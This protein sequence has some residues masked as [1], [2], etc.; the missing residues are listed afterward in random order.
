MGWNAQVDVIYQA[1]FYIWEKQKFKNYK[2][3]QLLME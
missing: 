2:I 3:G 1:L